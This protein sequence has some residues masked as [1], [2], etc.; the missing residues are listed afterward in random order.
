MS[1]LGIVGALAGMAFLGLAWAVPENGGPFPIDRRVGDLLRLDSSGAF[2]APVAALSWLG[3]REG[4]TVTALLAAVPFVLSRRLKAA[5]TILAASAGGGALQYLLKVGLPRPRPTGALLPAD[6]SSFPSGHALATVALWGVLFFVW[7]ATMQPRK[8]P[9]I[10]AALSALVIA[11][12]LT[13]LL[14][15]VHWFSDVLAGWCG[16]IAWAAI[17][18]LGTGASGGRPEAPNRR[19]D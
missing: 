18:L 17:V 5:M 14:L 4:I 8:V 6:G 10:A 11:I 9:W 3:S 13:R 19:S 7:R 15:G 1:R 12:G 2:V 16:G